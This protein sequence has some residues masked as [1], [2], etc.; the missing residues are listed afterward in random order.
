MY[1]WPLHVKRSDRVSFAT[2]RRQAKQEIIMVSGVRENVDL[3]HL[4]GETRLNHYDLTVATT[5][6]IHPD[7]HSLEGVDS[8]FF[9]E[10]TPRPRDTTF[11]VDRMVGIQP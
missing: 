8:S 10:F 3:T 6:T 4:A 1:G 11:R 9:S 7:P 5:K 2:S